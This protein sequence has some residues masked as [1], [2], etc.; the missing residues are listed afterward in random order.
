MPT[1]EGR[2]YYR[3]IE[4]FQDDL[5]TEYIFQIAIC[6]SLRNFVRAI[7]NIHFDRRRKEQM[8]K[9]LEE[10]IKESEYKL[11]QFQSSS[12]DAGRNCQAVISLQA[13][14]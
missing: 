1:G 6:I 14:T 4:I 11:T 7:K 2:C 8:S 10:I 13:D 5:K 3:G 12:I 9:I